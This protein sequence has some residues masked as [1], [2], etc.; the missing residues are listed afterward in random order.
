MAGFIRRFGFVPPEE[1]ITQIEG[2]SIVDLPPPGSIAG[3]NTGVVA[4]VGEF[5]DMTYAAVA[6]GSGVVSSSLR[7][8]EVTSAQDMLDKVGGF[9]STL[10]DFGNA[11]GNGF[12]ALRNKRF[13]RLIVCPINLCSATGVRYFRQLPLCT[14][15][16][17]TLPVVPVEGAQIDA[18]REFRSATSG[19]LKIGA[20]VVFTAFDPIT[21]GTGG[22][23]T[24]AAA[25]ATQTFTVAGADFS[26]V[27][28]PD[29][30]VGIKKGDL[31]VLGNNNAGALQPLPSG[32]SLGAGTY[33]VAA[34][35]TSGAPTVLSLEQL[36]GSN[37]AFVTASSIPYRI[38][39][40]SDADSAPVIVLGNS[41]PGGYAAADVG[42]YSVP[43]RPLT[44]EAGAVTD[45][46]WTAGLVINPLTVPAALTGSSWDPLSGLIGRIIPTG[47]MAFTALTQGPNAVNGSAIDS[48]YLAGLDA[49]ISN[50]AP[51]S[52]INVVCCARMSD[53]IRSGMKTH[54][55]TASARSLGRIAIIRPQLTTVSL[56]TALG[57]AAPG[58]GATR[59]ERVIYCWPGLRTYVPEAVN[60]RLK[61][62]DSL[63]TIDGVLDVGSD[64]YMAS[65]LSNLPPENNP[66]Q[67]VAPVPELMSTVL[68]LQRGAP[69]LDLA[70]YINLRARGVAAPRID[71]T[72]G[73]IFQSGITTSLTSGQKNVAR[74]RMADFIQDSTARTINTYSKMLLTDANKDS[75]VAEIDAFLAGLLSV[76]NPAAQRIADY[77]VDD[78]SGNTASRLAKGIFTVIVRVKTLASADFIVLQTEIGE[79]VVIQQELGQAA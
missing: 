8:Q 76:D 41:V 75:I 31:I 29:G 44:N 40:S 14:S 33:R 12:V 1:V 69:Q 36:Q 24:N 55:A 18:G 63:T 79:G 52:D 9:D 39:I 4:L 7:P 17:N 2:V 6:N 68:G 23:T 32:G 53:T 56:S 62:A 67:S 16:T 49:L 71:A 47:G 37:F 13:S 46:T 61:T 43:S 34:D 65:I 77:Q 66:G 58:V 28:R 74:R 10:G 57:D 15:Q 70:E 73:P 35:A 5:A 54:V 27:V 20:R 26:A 60:S 19:R 30:G 22:A 48:L 11:G 45:G 42:G 3:V 64:L 51:L 59:A 72:A 50:Q 21:T 38:H 78:K 25:A